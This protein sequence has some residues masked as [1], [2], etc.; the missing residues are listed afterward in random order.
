MEQHCYEICNL[1][2]AA[3]FLKSDA[4]CKGCAKHFCEEESGESL[5][6]TKSVMINELKTIKNGRKFQASNKAIKVPNVP[7]VIKNLD[8]AR[9]LKH[10]CLDGR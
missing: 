4:Q 1:E 10:T 6:T 5:V 8:M 7:E 2:T 3:E 9:C